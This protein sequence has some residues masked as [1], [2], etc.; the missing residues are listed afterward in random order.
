MSSDKKENQAHPD[1]MVAGELRIGSPTAYLLLYRYAH[2]DKVDLEPL[3]AHVNIS[4][5]EAKHAGSSSTPNSVAAC[6]AVHYA[7]LSVPSGSTG[8]L[9]AASPVDTSSEWSPGD[10]GEDSEGSEATG[11]PNVN[12]LQALQQ[13]FGVKH[14]VSK[15]FIEAAIDTIEHKLRP[16][17]DANIVVIA[18]Q[19]RTALELEAA[20]LAEFLGAMIGPEAQEGLLAMHK[21][22]RAAS[23][24]VRS[25]KR[26][27]KK[28]KDKH[29][30]GIY[31]G[32]HE[33]SRE[34]GRNDLD[35][36]SMVTYFG[37]GASKKSNA[38]GASGLV[39]RV[40]AHLVSGCLGYGT[41]R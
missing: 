20:G 29:L 31:G 11:T 13:E 3:A 36:G 10:S 22:L 6:A 4:G 24:Q 19:V 18:H 12:T 28:L 41:S 34:D 39:R 7:D 21:G 30:Q 26:I 8:S 35:E 17:R 23:S 40:Q 38:G 2:I 14:E 9:S 27:L 1:E 33:C 32:I 37:V 15:A 5:R 25:L 16:V